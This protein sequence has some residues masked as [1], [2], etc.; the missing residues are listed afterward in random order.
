MPT[1]S[2]TVRRVG[3]SEL[4]V[5]QLGI[6][7]GLARVLSQSGGSV[8]VDTYDFTALTSVATMQFQLV[9]RPAN[10]TT[11]ATTVAAWERVMLDCH[12]AALKSDVCGFD[13]WMDDHVGLSPHKTNATIGS[14]VATLDALGLKYHVNKMG[15]RRRLLA[16]DDVGWGG[17][18]ALY[19]STP[20]GL[21]I[22]I[23]GLQDG[24]YK[25]S[26][27]IG[28]GEVDLCNVGTCNKTAS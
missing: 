13:Q 20:S 5:R 11:G 8:A 3:K 4:Y 15:H 1:R 17:T 7:G 19:L 16:E 23:A 25:P 27:P 2:E 6:G 14:V 12:A 24:T 28:P 9:Q 18:H 22:S 21:A 10:A 26:Q